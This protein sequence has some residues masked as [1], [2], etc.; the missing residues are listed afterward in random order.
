MNLPRLL[1]GDISAERVTTPEMTI[2]SPNPQVNLNRHNSVAFLA[3]ADNV[4]TMVLHVKP[5]NNVERLP[6]TSAKTPDSNPL[7]SI[8]PK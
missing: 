2:P 7:T 4:P 1:G 6:Q 3:M 8:P 5:S